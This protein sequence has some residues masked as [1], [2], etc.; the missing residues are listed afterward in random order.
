[1]LAG[2][3]LLRHGNESRQQRVTNILRRERPGVAKQRG[4]T[5]SAG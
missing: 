3:L 5:D 4:V 1:M 2:D